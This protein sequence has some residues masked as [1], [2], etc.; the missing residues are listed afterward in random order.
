M[1]LAL[2][3][4]GKAGKISFIGFDASQTFIDAIEAGRCTAWSCRT[5]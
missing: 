1:L 3:D 4:I 5:R 2:Q